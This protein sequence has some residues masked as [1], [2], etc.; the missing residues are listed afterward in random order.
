MNST[1]SSWDISMLSDG[2]LVCAYIIYLGQRACHG[3]FNIAT[4]ATR[5]ATVGEYSENTHD[6]N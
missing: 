5:A 2:L 4:T 6:N 1:S 3:T